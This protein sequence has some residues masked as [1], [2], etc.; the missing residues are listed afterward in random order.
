MHAQGILAAM[1]GDALMCRC[2]Q[3]L[4]KYRQADRLVRVEP[5]SR[6][7][8]GEATDFVRQSFQPGTQ[9]VRFKLRRCSKLLN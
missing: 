6:L 8:T 4:L 5:P 9:R 1:P 3:W 2:R 7:R